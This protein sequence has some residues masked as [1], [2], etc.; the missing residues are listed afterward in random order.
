MKVCIPAILVARVYL[1]KMFSSNGNFLF[2]FDI[3]HNCNIKYV[4]TTAKYIFGQL[5]V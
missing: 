4:L 2:E 5:W 3:C 1:K